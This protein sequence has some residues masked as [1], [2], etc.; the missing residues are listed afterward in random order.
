MVKRIVEADATVVW[1]DDHRFSYIIVV[2]D[3]DGEIY[4][5]GQDMVFKDRLKRRD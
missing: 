1:Q 4:E 2:E 3:E 5:H